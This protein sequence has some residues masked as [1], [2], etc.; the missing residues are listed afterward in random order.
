MVKRWGFRRRILGEG[1]GRSKLRSK[2]FWVTKADLPSPLQS[3]VR[4]LFNAS[5]EPKP[6]HIHP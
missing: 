2:G 6:V 4:W 3:T 5:F 1:K